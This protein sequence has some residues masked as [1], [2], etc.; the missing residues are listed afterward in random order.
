MEALDT[1][2]NSSEILTWIAFLS[3]IY[4]YSEQDTHKEKY[5]LSTEV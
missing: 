4:V 1:A 2:V 3:T 5:M